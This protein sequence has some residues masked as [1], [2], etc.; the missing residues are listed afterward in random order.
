MPLRESLAAWPP[1]SL[2]AS[3]A[4]IHP[5]LS[6]Q[7]LSLGRNLIKKIEGLDGVSDT[8]EELWISYNLIDKLAG[9]EKASG[10]QGAERGS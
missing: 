7:V 1:P 8:L 6:P 3:D 5:L 9:L 2:L 4:P 10:E